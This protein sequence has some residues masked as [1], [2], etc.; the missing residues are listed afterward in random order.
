MDKRQTEMEMEMYS[1]LVPGDLL[2]I[3]GQG[4]QGELLRSKLVWLQQDYL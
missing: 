3:P 1:G 4:M 2:K